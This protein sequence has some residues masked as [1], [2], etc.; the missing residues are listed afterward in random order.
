MRALFPDQIQR[1][2]PERREH[3]VIALIGIDD[4]PARVRFLDELHALGASGQQRQRQ[5][6]CRP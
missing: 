1:L 2:P 3:G 5:D 4:H 6:S